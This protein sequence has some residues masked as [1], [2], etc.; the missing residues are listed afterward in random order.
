MKVTIK[1]Y[2]ELIIHE[3]MEY[4]AEDLVKLHGL[5]QRAGAL[6]PPLHWTD[7]VIFG[8]HGMPH[9]AP[10]VKEMVEGRLHW[11]SVTFAV[12]PVYP[13]VVTIKET[14]VKVPI[15]DVSN[16]EIFRDV[17]RALKQLAKRG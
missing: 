12:F 5:G 3:V 17:A 11:M 10:I 2:D 6:A 9:I 8:F 15:I 4:N 1:P 13:S 14:N 7:G 16:S